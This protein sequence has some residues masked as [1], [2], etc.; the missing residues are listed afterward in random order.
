MKCLI[1]KL[2][3]SGIIPRGKIMKAVDRL[4]VDIIKTHVKVSLLIIKY[5]NELVNLDMRGLGVKRFSSSHILL[6][7][8]KV[9]SN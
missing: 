9:N 1:D 8:I 3:K 7:K 2:G 5:V 6:W 4:Y